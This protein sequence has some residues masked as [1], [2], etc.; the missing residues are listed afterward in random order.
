MG[1]RDREWVDFA[2]D[3]ATGIARLR[4]RFVRHRYDRH[5]HDDYAIGMTEAGSQTFD[6]RG[7]R[8]TTR[9]GAL[10]LFNPG[11]LHDGRATGTDGFVYRMLY[12][13][14]ATMR[15]LAGDVLARDGHEPLFA[16]PLA[17]DPATAAAITA[18]FDA[19]ATDDAMARGEMLAMLAARLL[20]RHA[21]IRVADDTRASSASL[22]RA[23][24]L[25]EAHC[26]EPT[27]L[28][29]I[30][31]EAGLSRFHLARAFRR[32]FGMSPSEFR[33]LR[34]LDRA[35]GLLARGA[36]P[37][38]AAADAGFADQAHLTRLFKRAYG[39]TPGQYRRAT[40]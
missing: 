15:A 11:E 30:A 7:G 25:I 9:P 27:D 22:L 13:P 28:S 17:C 29:A 39:V 12:V 5:S 36:A 19:L 33:R 35:R 2:R 10:T 4:A 14:V 38:E 21:G 3:G 40:A 34:R 6:C 18:A 26:A 31:R 23:R 1:E 24:A 8:H 32:R 20:E 16:S 37:C